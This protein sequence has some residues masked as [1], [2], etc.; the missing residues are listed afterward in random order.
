MN[1]DRFVSRIRQALN[2]DL[3]ELPQTTLRRME[4]ARHHA[5]ARQ[6]Q[7]VFV[8]EMVAAGSAQGKS[9]AHPFLEN[10]RLR[11]FLTVLA[12][13][14]GMALAARWQAQDYIFGIEEVDSALLTDDL[15]PEAFL[16]KGFSAWLMDDSSEE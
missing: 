2:H 7:A 11:Q 13:L 16:D 6:K 9:L 4:A 8:P 5:L 12:L 10:A 1:E 14:V 15:P 3:D